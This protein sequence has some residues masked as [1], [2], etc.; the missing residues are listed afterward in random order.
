ME[1]AGTNSAL[2]QILGDKRR[3]LPNLGAYRKAVAKREDQIAEITLAGIRYREERRQLRDLDAFLDQVVAGVSPAPGRPAPGCVPRSSPWPS[4]GSPCSI[5]CK[6][7]PKAMRNGLSELNFEAQQ[8]VDTAT[9]YDDYLSERLLW[10]RS[11][12]PFDRTVIAG[13][14]SAIAWLLSPTGWL[15]VAQTLAYQAIHSPL[16]GVLLLAVVGLMVPSPGFAPSNPRHRRTA[17][18]R[19]HRSVRLHAQG[20]RSVG[21]GCSACLGTDGT[22]WLAAGDLGRGHGLREGGR[23]GPRQH[24]A[25]VLYYLR[26]FRVLCMPGGVADKHFR[27]PSDVL[28]RLRR[29]FDWLVFFLL[30]VGFVAQV[31]YNSDDAAHAGSLGDVWRC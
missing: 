10:V 17:A 13:L 7:P 15:E 14:P 23:A 3:Q 12:L 9:A 1:V 4:A 18:P 8:L 5:P 16:F 27:W 2:G 25:V 24:L 29:T 31:I 19:A 11:V 20:H 6:P 28:I 26:S 21:L 30:P 22:A